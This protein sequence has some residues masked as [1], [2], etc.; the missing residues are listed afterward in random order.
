MSGARISFRD[1]EAGN[2]E[3]RICIIRGQPSAIR[4]AEGL[5]QEAVAS[6]VP[7]EESFMLVPGWAVGR[8]IGQYHHKL[9]DRMIK[10]C[11]YYFHIN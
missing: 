4:V 6:H 7:P 8:I 9:K 2:T 1:A 5:I 10:V 3:K 11:D